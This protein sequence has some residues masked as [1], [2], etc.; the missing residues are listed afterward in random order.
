MIKMQF[1]DKWDVIR[2]LLEM[3]F[4]FENMVISPWLAIFQ[5]T[6]DV[7]LVLLQV[8]RDWF[9]ICNRDLI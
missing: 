3:V 7:V 4:I 6:L 1:N 9:N 8:G 2:L 5:P